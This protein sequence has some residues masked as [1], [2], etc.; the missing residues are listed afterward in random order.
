MRQWR[1]P[2]YRHETLW[3]NDFRSSRSDGVGIEWCLADDVPVG[4]HTKKVVWLYIIIQEEAVNY[5]RRSSANNHTLVSATNLNSS[6]TISTCCLI[7]LLFSEL[8]AETASVLAHRIRL[9][10]CM[11]AS[12]RESAR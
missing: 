2:D 12:M 4:R 1:H 7:S 8:T 9:V 5:Q 11:G 10:G 6:K 3:L